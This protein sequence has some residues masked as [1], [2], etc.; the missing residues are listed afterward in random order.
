M[1]SLASAKNFQVQPAEVDPW[2]TRS[3]AVNG[4]NDDDE[5]LQVKSQA[6]AQ[7]LENFAKLI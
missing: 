3:Q 2:D 1:V 7:I 6:F 4:I 5:A